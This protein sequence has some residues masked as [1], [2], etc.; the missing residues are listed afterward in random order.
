MEKTALTTGATAKTSKSTSSYAAYVFWVLYAISFLNYL[1]RYVLAG[2]ANVVAKELGFQLDGIG[3]ITSAFIIVYT[4]GAL[5]LSLWADRSKRK[6]VVAV[7]VAFW[8]CATMVTALAVNFTTLFLSRMFLGV[9]EAGHFPAGTAMMSDYFRRERRSRIMSWWSTAQLFGILGGYVAGGA[10]A[11][12]FV[13]SWRLAFICTGVPG[14]VLAFLAWRMRE[15]RRNQADEEAR[16]DGLELPEEMA[17]QAAPVI[18]GGTSSTSIQDM[19]KQIALQI[20]DLLRIKTLAVLIIMQVFAFFVL[21]VNTT[22]LPTYLQQGDIYN[23]S[24]GQAGLYSGVIIVLAGIV[25][26]S[27]GGFMADWLNRKHGGAR[28]LVCGV[29]FL[30]SAPSFALAVTSRNLPIFTVFFVLTA[31][32]IT[33]YTGPSTAATQDVVPSVMRASAV[34]ISLL[35]AHLLGDAFAPSLV[36][37]LATAFDPTHG[38]HFRNGMAGQDLSHALLVSCVPALLIAGLLGVW[39][40]RWMKSDVEAAERA[41]GAVIKNM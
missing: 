36:G 9:G 21:G 30:L 34:G 39:G 16:L 23:M 25:G 5:P 22:F 41:D 7:C 4:L 35:L 6:N 8:S 11:G 24:S 19:V 13:G 40:A 32:L 20:R 18:S 1:D 12:L 10:L 28:V 3:F 26:T 38:Q 29:G 31:L 37:I 27:L 33:I 14:L 15:P 17:S 2:A